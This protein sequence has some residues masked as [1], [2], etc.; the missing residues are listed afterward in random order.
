MYIVHHQ[1]KDQRV[2]QLNCTKNQKP[3]ISHKAII[4]HYTASSNAISA[5]EHLAKHNTK[6][7]AHMVIG[8]NASIY[9]IV[10][11]NIQAW[12]AGTSHYKNLKNLNKYSIGIEL[13]NAGKL[14]KINNNYVSWFGKIYKPED[15]YTHNPGTNETYWHKYTEEQLDTLVEICREITATYPIRTILG[16]S[17]ITQRKLDPGPAFP[18]ERFRELVLR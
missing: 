4:I 11:F 16:H 6:V 5:A 2:H 3:L 18:M 7:S 14:D 12:H 1:L 17:D 10:P 9:Q 13:D 8:R 15:V